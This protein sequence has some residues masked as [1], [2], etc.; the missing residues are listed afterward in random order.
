MRPC[1][2]FL[3]CS[4]VNTFRNGV[5]GC[6]ARFP[7]RVTLLAI[8]SLFVYSLPNTT[9][10]QNHQDGFVEVA[11][12][13]FVRFGAHLEISK[14]TVES[15]ANTGFIIGEQSVAVIDPGGSYEAVDQ[16]MEAVRSKTKLPVSHVV[17]THMHPDHSLG[18]FRFIFA[19]ASDDNP[20]GPIASA[21]SPLILGHQKLWGAIVQNADFFRRHFSDENSDLSKALQIDTLLQ[22]NPITGIEH[23]LTIDLGE[24]VLEIHAH[25]TAHTSNDVSIF[26]KNTGTLWAGDLIFAERLPAL[27]GNLKGWVK[28]VR[29]LEN[30]GP[31][32]I[33]PGHG[34]AAGWD[35]VG[36]PLLEYLERLLTWTRDAVRQGRSLSEFIATD[37]PW[38]DPTWHLFDEQQKINM[39]RAYSELEWE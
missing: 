12:G 37:W 28:T 22:L 24:R 7:E 20:S 29:K 35:T 11:A 17:V 33:V 38:N 36:A 30:L 18:L 32:M 9:F 27:D 8:S 39:S 19:T 14:Q 21:N 34:K 4:I 6:R 15:I 5:N 23:Q 2:D 3:L 10:S 13:N 16:M 1:V 31:V 25:S 26:D